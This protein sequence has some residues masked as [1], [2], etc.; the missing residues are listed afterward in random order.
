M[1]DTIKVYPGDTLTIN[2]GVHVVFQGHYQFLVQGLLQAVGTEVDF[3]YFTATNTL[4]GWGG[5]RFQNAH[6]N[7]RLEYCHLEWGNA[8][9]DFPNS[10]GGAVYI[11][12]GI[13]AVKTLL[14]R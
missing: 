13:S 6:V 8:Q 11:Y 7:S 12:G 4:T 9:G 3:I 5:I 14:V 10:C 2:P 1:A